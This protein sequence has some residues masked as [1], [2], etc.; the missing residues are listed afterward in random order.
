MESEAYI[1]LP[2]PPQKLTGSLMSI[3]LIQT[4]G[5]ATAMAIALL[6]ALSLYPFRQCTFQPLQCLVQGW[7]VLQPFLNHP[8]DV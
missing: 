2:I 1:V 5:W 8:L 3:M 7:I 4:L 6:K